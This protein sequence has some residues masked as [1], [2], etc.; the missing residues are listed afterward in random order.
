MRRENYGALQRLVGRNLRKLRLEN[1]MS[2]DKYAAVL[3]FARSYMGDVERGVRN[4]T[5]QSVEDL[6]HRAGVSPHTLLKPDEAY[7]NEKSRPADS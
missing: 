2:Q 7:D 1:G 4:L 5:L 3:G 6:A